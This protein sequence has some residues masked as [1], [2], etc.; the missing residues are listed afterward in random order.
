[1]TPELELHIMIL[2]D[3][4]ED[5]AGVVCN[6]YS[7][8]ADLIQTL[9]AFGDEQNC[10]P[11][12]ICCVEVTLRRGWLDF[13]ERQLLLFRRIAVRSCHKIQRSEL[14][15]KR[16][17]VHLRLRQ[18]CGARRVLNCAGGETLIAVVKLDALIRKSEE[19]LE[20]L[21][22]ELFSLVESLHQEE[23]GAGAV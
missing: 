3:G 2:A 14:E 1:M 12:I 15:V 22:W 23:G 8:I 11:K 17:Q 21:D 19:R 10:T 13:A 18:E 20:V 6:E 4:T 7:G 9:L 5:D 16:I